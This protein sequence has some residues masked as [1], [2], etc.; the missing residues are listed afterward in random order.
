MTATNDLSVMAVEYSLS[1][2]KCPHCNAYL[3]VIDNRP[4]DEMYFTREVHQCG[5]CGESMQVTV[6][7]EMH[8]EIERE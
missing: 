3:N 8:I 5:A 2:E 6:W 7:Y 1:D 4:P